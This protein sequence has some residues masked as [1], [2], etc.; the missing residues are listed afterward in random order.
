MHL[1]LSDAETTARTQK[2]HDIIES[3]KYPFSPRIRNLRAILTKLRPE[4]VCQ[5]V[6]PWKVYAR[7]RFL[8]AVPENLSP[9]FLMQASHRG[10]KVL[11]LF[12]FRRYPNVASVVRL[13]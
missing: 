6:L 8:V 4:P 12:S 7:P 3:G 10:G 9:R 11:D 1:A 13:E 5:P 2:L